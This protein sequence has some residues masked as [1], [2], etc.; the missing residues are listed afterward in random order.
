MTED[1]NNTGI[2]VIIY[3]GEELGESIC[4]N[5][6]IDTKILKPF[7][8]DIERKEKNYNFKYLDNITLKFKGRKEIESIKNCFQCISEK[9]EKYLKG[10]K[11]YEEPIG[12]TSLFSLIANVNDYDK[13]DIEPWPD[14]QSFFTL[15]DLKYHYHRY[16]EYCRIKSINPLVISILDINKDNVRLIY[17]YSK[18]YKG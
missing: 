15:E 7:D 4:I 16:L 14:F 11:N 12:Q 13:K 10:E 6:N 5:L 8:L 3:E 2:E 18:E 9:L 1:K 17:N